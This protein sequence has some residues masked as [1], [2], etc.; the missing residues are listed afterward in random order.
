MLIIMLYR[1]YIRATA[2]VMITVQYAG[3]WSCSML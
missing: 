1:S 2:P 3:Y